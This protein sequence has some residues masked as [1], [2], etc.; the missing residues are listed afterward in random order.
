VNIFVVLLFLAGWMGTSHFLP[1]VSWHAEV[2]FFMATIL[3]AW[4][5]I[6]KLTRSGFVPDIFLPAPAAPLLIML[7][8]T[9]IQGVLGVT[10][11]LGDVFVFSLYL[12]LCLIC[13]IVGYGIPPSVTSGTRS[14]SVW[15]KTSVN[16]MAIILVVAGLASVLVALVQILQV[17]EASPWILR[18]SSVRRP[19]GNLGQPNHLATLLVMSIASVAYLVS[20][21]RVSIALA[22]LLLFVMCCGLALTESRTGALSFFALL[23]W[24]TWKQ[25]KVAPTWSHWP[26]IGLAILFATLFLG[27]PWLYGV[28]SGA[29]E[30]TFRL[31]ATAGNAR[32]EV[33]PQLVAAST[34]RP[35]FGWGI[36]QTAEA[37][38]SVAHLYSKGESFSYSHNLILDLVLW[39]GLPLTIVMVL[40]SI[41]WLWSRVRMIHSLVPWYGMAVAV[42]LGVHSM[43]EFPFAYAYFLVPVM[44]L[45]GVMERSLE[46]RSILRVG[47]QPAVWVLLFVTI[48]SVWS[49]IEYLRAEDE[50]RIMRFEM[51][52]IGQT[53]ADHQSPK[54]LIQTQLG[55]LIASTKIEPKPNMSLE[56]LDKLKQVAMR[57][58][59]TA[60]RY[61]YS[62]S[63]ALNHQTDEAT[64]QMQIIRVHEGEKIYSRL[65]QQI[66]EK[67]TGLGLPALGKVNSCEQMKLSC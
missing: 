53:P 37:H 67:V 6:F 34:Q 22:A 62:F 66:N 23:A 38:N 33:W 46:K 35:W 11:F 29:E 45:I 50:F 5:A 27:W 20:S 61:R 8:V 49:A 15:W 17:W 64:R 18:Q 44:Y 65:S 58:P 24:W 2:P 31:G 32:A 43:L 54:I 28:L 10:P 16:L 36:L 26:A 52:R 51:L 41:W 21:K 1:W 55:A 47:V 42:P 30:S 25:P 9:L 48:T 57:Y 14:T 4:F 59:W 39:V 7:L 60:T 19:G 12:S 63:L 40:L 3:V 56:D 13:L